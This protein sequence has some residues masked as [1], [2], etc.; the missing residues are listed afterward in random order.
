MVCLYCG[1]KTH[2]I[3]SRA[4]QRANQVWR[5]RQCWACQ[6]IFT[7]EEVAAYTAAWRVRS[8]T[9]GLQPFSRD[10]LFLSLYKSCGHRQN[11]V[12]DAG[13]L[14]DTVINKLG[15]WVTDGIVDWQTIV[16]TAQ[17]ALS[18]FDAVASVHY[19]AF[20]A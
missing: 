8:S 18:R 19:A 7:T 13:A 2:I 3:N 6:A 15:P 12:Q 11:A 10:R 1:A 16:Q 20:H 17:V 5:R 14:T 4:Q 9:G